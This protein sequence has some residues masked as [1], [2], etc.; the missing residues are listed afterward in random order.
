M[1]WWRICVNH[2]AVRIGPSGNAGNLS[3]LLLDREVF[4]ND[5]LAEI[6][7]VDVDGGDFEK[8]ELDPNERTGLLTQAGWLAQHSAVKHDSPIFRGLFVYKRMLCMPDPG[9]PEETSTVPRGGTG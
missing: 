3:D 1:R 2:R 7:G 9:L 8:V 4:V 5:S 6:Y